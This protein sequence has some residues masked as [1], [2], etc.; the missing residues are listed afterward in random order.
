MLVNKQGKLSNIK[1]W[2]ELYSHSATM[3]SILHH[4]RTEIIRNYA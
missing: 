3:I 1:T 4:K 2:T